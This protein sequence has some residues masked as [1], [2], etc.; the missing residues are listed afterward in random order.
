MSLCLS[1]CLSVSASPGHAVHQRSARRQRL[2]PDGWHL[3]PMV[4]SRRLGGREEE[5]LREEH[6]CVLFCNIQVVCVCITAELRSHGCIAIYLH[7]SGIFKDSI[8]VM[9][10]AHIQPYS[11]PHRNT[12]VQVPVNSSSRP[13]KFKFWWRNVSVNQWKKTFNTRHLPRYYS[14]DQRWGLFVPPALQLANVIMLNLLCVFA[15]TFKFKLPRRPLQ[16]HLNLGLS[17]PTTQTKREK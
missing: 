7:S 8:V 13:Q 4:S 6:V 3:Q 5:C 12:Q 9:C 15:A 17:S 16:R 10:V 2:R 1:T 14:L 11:P